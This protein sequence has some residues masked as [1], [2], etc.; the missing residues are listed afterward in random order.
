MFDSLDEQMKKDMNKETSPR[1]RMPSP[2][3][4]MPSPLRLTRLPRRPKRPCRQPQPLRLL[5]HKLRLVPMPRLW[6][7]PLP[8]HPL[9]APTR[10]SLL[11]ASSHSS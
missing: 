10:R 6:L 2:T 1:Q 3:A 8:P 5:T 11:A 4:R 9:P 7:M